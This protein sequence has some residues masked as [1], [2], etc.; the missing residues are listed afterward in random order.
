[1]ALNAYDLCERISFDPDEPT[2][3]FG[4][5]VSDS[6]DSRSI[7]RFTTAHQRE[8]FAQHV[9][10]SL[11]CDD[12]RLPAV[13]LLYLLGDDDQVDMAG[14]WLDV[15]ADGNCIDGGFDL[16]FDQLESMRAFI[17]VIAV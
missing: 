6:S 10:E 7:T 9:C 16:R 1:M 3:Y 14:H 11:Q 5:Y 15:I 12:D 2:E 13:M 8:Q 17:E 4:Y